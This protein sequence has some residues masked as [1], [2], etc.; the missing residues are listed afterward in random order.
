MLA[1]MDVSFLF[2]VWVAEKRRLIDSNFE[3][4]HGRDPSCS[5]FS[6][7]AMRCEQTQHHPD[8]CIKAPI[9]T[10]ICAREKIVHVHGE[11]PLAN[12]ILGC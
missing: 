11:F 1:P 4:V 7:V 8:L 5:N 6:L 10:R 3:K 2:M 12:L 9:F